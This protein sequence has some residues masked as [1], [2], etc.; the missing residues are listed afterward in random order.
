MLTYKDKFKEV[1]G[2]EPKDV[3][4]CLACPCVLGF[5]SLQ[6]CANAVCC[7]ICKDDFWN[8]QYKSIKE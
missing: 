7:D 3:Y 6:Q 8:S 1:F 2:V 4:N 5:K